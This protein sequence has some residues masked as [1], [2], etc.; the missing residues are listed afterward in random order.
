MERK[1]QT[2]DVAVAVDPALWVFYPFA[3]L[4]K[5]A[6]LPHYSP[7]VSFSGVNKPCDSIIVI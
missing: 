4:V 5:C 6:D 1:K 7:S 2:P 3:H